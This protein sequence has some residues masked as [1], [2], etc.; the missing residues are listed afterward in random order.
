MDKADYVIRN[1]E[2]IK[3]GDAIAIIWS[4]DDVQCIAKENYDT[5]LTQDELRYVL[6]GMRRKHDA[7]IG[8]NWGVIDYWVET[9]VETRV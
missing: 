5:T 9:V 1:L 6:D 3:S 7:E 2:D 8:I 4:A